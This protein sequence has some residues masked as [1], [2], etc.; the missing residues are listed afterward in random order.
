MRIIADRTSVGTPG[1]A[2]QFLNQR[3]RVM[4]IH[5]KPFGD[6]TGFVYFGGSTVSSTDNSFEFMPNDPKG[7]LFDFRPGTVEMSTFYVDADL[8]NEGVSWIAAVE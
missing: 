7:Q 6:N 4:W 8:A 5:V 3:D 1:T 2:V